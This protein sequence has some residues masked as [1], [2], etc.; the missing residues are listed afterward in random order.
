LFLLSLCACLPQLTAPEAGD[1][2]IVT[3]TADDTAG[4]TSPPT[5][6]TGG[7]DT[8][9][10]DTSPPEE[11][12]DSAVS[13]VPGDSDG[14]GFGDEPGMEDCDDKNPSVYPGA[15]KLCDGQDTDCDGEIDGEARAS[16][17]AADGTWSD[18][19]DVFRGYGAYTFDQ[20]GTLWFCA[21]NW[22]AQ[23]EITAKQAAI[24]GRDG[25]DVT[26]LD[27]GQQQ[28]LRSVRAAV[29][30]EGLNIANGGSEANG[31]CV[32]VEGG[33][34]SA[35][36]V[37]FYD[38][39]A[40][41]GGGAIYIDGGAAVTLI[42]ARLEDN[43]AGRGGAIYLKDGALHIEDSVVIDNEAHSDAGGGV[44]L[45]AGSVRAVMTDWTDNVAIDVYLTTS[46]LRYD[47]G[48]AASFLCDIDGCY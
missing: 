20:E 37:G 9:T 11:T 7:D 8:E 36:G 35:T 3:E 6:S 40:T 28:P 31:G 48:D 4:D 14:D 42:G 24:R 23:I 5:D 1:T 19:S 46:N 27:G 34:F 16:F 18:L 45:D 21:G 15:P 41:V 39:K 47:Y 13:T 30:V 44:T 32:S 43:R 25:P 2:E 10:T 12:G 17:Q 22:P 33:S 26:V 29:E 38:C